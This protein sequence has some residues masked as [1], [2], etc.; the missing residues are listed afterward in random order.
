MARVVTMN[1]FVVVVVFNV[2]MMIVFHVEIPPILL[3]DRLEAE[4]SRLDVSREKRFGI[5]LKECFRLVSKVY[6]KGI[7]K[8]KTLAASSSNNNGEET[9]ATTTTTTSR[10]IRQIKLEPILQLSFLRMNMI[11]IKRIS[12]LGINIIS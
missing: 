4:P 8:K 6:D 7:K 2:G 9:T 12:F 11:S 5:S 1:P 10:I 3:T